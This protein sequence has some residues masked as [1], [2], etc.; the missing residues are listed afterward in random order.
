MINAAWEAHN[1][2]SP[3]NLASS[4]INEY[5]KSERNARVQEEEFKSLV[6]QIDHLN[7]R[8]EA[9]RLSLTLDRKQILELIG[10]FLVNQFLTEGS[11]GSKFEVTD[12]HEGYD[13][14]LGLANKM[15]FAKLVGETV[16][17]KWVFAE[18]DKAEKLNP[19]EV[20]IFMLQEGPRSDIKFGPVFVSEHKVL[21]GR[22]RVLTVTD[23]LKSITKG[24]FVARLDTTATKTNDG[25]RFILARNDQVR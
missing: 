23:L 5:Q 18:A 4:A 7:L 10:I 14:M 12:N 13:G 9:G 15:V 17:E 24:R 25:N 22:F 2:L 21:R 6:K 11:W 20:W 1:A 16:S 19:S 3:L 8:N